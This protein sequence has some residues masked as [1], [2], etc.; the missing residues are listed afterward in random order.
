[1]ISVEMAIAISILPGYAL[2][3]IETLSVHNDA[4]P[5]F[6]IDTFGFDN[7]G[8]I[9]LEMKDLQVQVDGKTIGPEGE[10]GIL[11][12]NVDT[13]IILRME[14]TIDLCLIEQPGLEI[15]DSWS[16]DLPLT[17][18]KVNAHPRL[19]EVHPVLGYRGHWCL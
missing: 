14:E 6:T 18:P 2:G 11:V 5:M 13:E 15:L 4:R 9:S 19:A 7:G 3:A 10:V 1:M 12:S 8:K 17:K 16:F